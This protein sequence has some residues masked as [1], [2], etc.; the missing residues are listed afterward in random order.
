MASHSV[1]DESSDSTSGRRGS[2]KFVYT[3]AEVEELTGLSRSTVY[4]E[5]RD[6]RLFSIRIRGTR[7]VPAD[8]LRRYIAELVRDARE[9][10]P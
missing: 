7:R 3:I 6:G 9:A 5:L 4:R 10:T 1:E 2:P 8:A